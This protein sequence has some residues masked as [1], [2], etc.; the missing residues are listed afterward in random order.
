MFVDN[1]GESVK[2][3]TANMIKVLCKQRAGLKIC[4]INAQ[5]L[6]NKLDEFR[7]IF[8]NSG[9]DLI[10][11]SET[12]F[13]SN[14]ADG[15]IS[16]EGYNVVRTD[17][18]SR[19]GGVAIYF[20]KDLPLR[21]ISRSGEHDQVEHIFVEIKNRKS[22]I[23]LGTVY[24]P[25]RYIN[26]DS[27]LSIL[28]S[29]SIMYSDILIA[30]DFN[31]N[32]LHDSSLVDKISP[33]GLYPVNSSMPTHYSSYCNTLLDVFLVGDI[34]KILLYDQ[35]NASCFSKHDLIFATYNFEP[36]I[37][38]NSFIYR[39]FKNI[40]LTMLEEEFLK[41]DWN[42]IYSLLTVDEQV[43]FLENN[44]EFLYNLTVPLRKKHKSVNNRPWFSD[45]IKMSISQRNLAFS[46][47]KRYKIEEFHEIYKNL[48]R[49][50]NRLIKKAKADYYA[51]K[52][53][54]AVRSKKTWQ[55][56]RELGIG[57]SNKNSCAVVD[58]D[59]LN[60]RF[61][62]IPYIEPDPNYQYQENASTETFSFSCINQSDVLSACLGIK[63]NAIGSVDIHPKFLKIILPFLLPFITNIFNK[64]LT[65]SIFP[66]SWKTAKI[67][68]L[69]KSD[70]DF[71]PIAILPFLSKAFERILHI[72]ISNFLETNSLLSE[73]QSGFRARHSCITALID[74]VEDIR[75]DLDEDKLIFLVLLDHTKAFDMVDHHT[76]CSKLKSLFHFQCSAIRLIESYLT[77]RHQYVETGK[78]KSILLPVTRGVPQGAIIGPLLF[79]LYINDLPN[80]VANCNL[81]LYADDVQLYMSC[82]K[83]LMDE[84]VLNL[85]ANLNTVYNWATA[86]GLAVN[87]AKS[88]CLIIGKRTIL[89]SRAPHILINGQVIPFVDTA[90]NLGIVFNSTLTWSNHINSICGRTWSMIRNLWQTQH[91]TPIKTR[92][93]LAKAYLM[94]TLLYG[95]ELFAG[96][97]A[98]GI[99]MLNSTFNNILRYVFGLNKF[100][101][102]SP[103]RNLLY[104]ISFENLLKTKVLIMLH[105]LI[106]NRQPSHLFRRIIFSRSNRGLKINFLRYN[107]LI[108]SRQFFVN[109]FRL[110]NSL[111]SNI[112]LIS[113][114]LHFK[115]SITKHFS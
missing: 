115:I 40:D 108:S 47:W 87:P 45:Q 39:D 67:V 1:C 4:H 24:R 53:S 110:W 76:L 35:L 64:I 18:K 9:V 66:T 109:A 32:I 36:P 100:D 99:K 84:C 88:K 23:L 105:K 82:E 90:K 78:T 71:R 106:Y 68:P 28:E 74:V 54:D 95:C 101:H 85:N 69:P 97:D 49:A 31:C 81:R 96:C 41:I 37:E 16:L 56:I 29:Y 38:Q 57:N 15:T 75:A 112:Q 107:T 2:D 44:L 80:Y 60:E 62:N 79:S 93:L 77:N 8:E 6:I 114:A 52:F 19:G 22:K 5:S 43:A 51:R 92:I 48:R 46:R 73:R 21:V 50:T 63:S 111:P 72:Q 113:N 27:F 25:N 14:I 12:W 94:P 7:F 86:N 42:C 13:N 98:K 91:C 102:I 104:G 65:T 70:S 30:G 89:Q 33:I 26:F 20:K 61:L 10:C 17:R 103:Y 55:T 83:N 3:G 34:S 58:A 59:Y 11:I